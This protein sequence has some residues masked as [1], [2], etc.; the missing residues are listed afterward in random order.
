MRSL[1][2]LLAMS[3]ACSLPCGCHTGRDAPEPSPGSA[4]PPGAARSPTG[5]AAAAKSASAEP[6]ALPPNV[7]HIVRS[8]IE[9]E[10]THCFEKGL[11][12]APNQLGSVLLVTKVKPDG[13]VD[14]VSAG[15]DGTLSIETVEC[16]QYVV[17]RAEF[18]PP[19]GDA[20]TFYRVQLTFPH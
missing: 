4:N 7:E 13:K 20:G 10:A 14:T 2:Y 8:Q 19:G 18:D 5:G 15:A 6:A 1:P 12:E 16:I 11:K 3:V 17:K 9:P